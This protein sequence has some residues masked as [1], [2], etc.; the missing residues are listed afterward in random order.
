[1][2]TTNQ[3]LPAG[4]MDDLDDDDYKALASFRHSLRS[5]FAFSEDAA[6]KVGLPPQQHQAILAVRSLSTGRGA[7]VGSVANHLLLKP[8]TAVGLIDRL[9]RGDLLVRIQ[10]QE[11]RRRV[12]LTLTPKANEALRALSAIHLTEIRRNAPELIDLL[13]QLSA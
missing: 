7:T 13:R 6:R 3:Q 5:F 8:H 4:P 2:M 9:V 1:M 12:L 10:D 11:D